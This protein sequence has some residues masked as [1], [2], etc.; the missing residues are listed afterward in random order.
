MGFRAVLA[1]AERDVRSTSREK[2]A[3]FWLILFPIMMLTFSFLLWANPMPPVTL[4]VGVVLADST[5]DMPGLNFTAKNITAIMEKVELKT[6]EGEIVKLFRLTYYDSEEKAVD[7]LL[8]GELDAVVIFPEGFSYNLSLGFTANVEIYILGGD[9]YKEQVA[10][11]VLTEFFNRLSDTV[12][13]IRIE[14]M[15]EY[16]PPDVPPE[17]IEWMRGLAWPVNASITVKTPKTLMGRAGLRGWFTMAMA[18]VEFLIAG[19]AMGATMVVEERERGTL[20]RLL[21]APIGPWDLLFG[22]TLSGLVWLGIS[23]LTCLF[24]G[25]AWGARIYWN[26]L[27]NPAHALVPVVLLLGALTSLGMGLLISTISKTARGASGLATAVSWPLMFLT[28]IWMPKWMLPGPLQALADWFPIT[29]A[30]DAVRN[31]MVFNGG[32][33]AIAPVLPSLV[34][35]AIV[36]YGLGALAYKYVL[37]R[38]V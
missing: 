18:G 5:A 7:D 13:H 22:K 37:R 20:R 28:G 17:A 2:M 9:T 33:E 25:L 16:M 3:L 14:I 1:I 30:V 36:I 11:A 23:A 21:A 34:V 12:A 24:Y 26:P 32:L 31:V 10:R 8:S 38:S 15:G 6:E 4:D 35:F 19:M 27:A 29:I